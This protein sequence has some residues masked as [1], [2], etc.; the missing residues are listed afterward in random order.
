[1]VCCFLSAGGLE[2]ADFAERAFITQQVDAEGLTEEELKIIKV[3]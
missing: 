3:S 1:M 2:G